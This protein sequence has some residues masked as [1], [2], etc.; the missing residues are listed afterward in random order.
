MLDSGFNFFDTSEGYAKGESER[1]L[2]E[3]HQKD[4]KDIII[5][6]KYDPTGDPKDVLKS[7]GGSLRRLGMN[8]IDLL[9]LHYPPKKG[10]TIEQFMDVMSETVK[11]GKTR[12][13]GVSNLN[14]ECIADSGRQKWK[15]SQRQYRRSE[16]QAVTA[17]L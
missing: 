14:A 11:S 10:T 2:G 8:R 5:A 9:Q 16:F 1:I 17:R 6:S 3:F 7:L 15:A 13:I 12:A 4:G